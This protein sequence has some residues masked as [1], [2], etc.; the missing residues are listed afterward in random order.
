MGT[1]CPDVSDSCS[2]PTPSANG[3]VGGMFRLG[4]FCVWDHS[5]S[6]STGHIACL[7]CYKQVKHRRNQQAVRAWRGGVEGKEGPSASVS[8]SVNGAWSNT[9]QCCPLA[10]LPVKYYTKLIIIAF[11]MFLAIKGV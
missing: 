9:L 6:M 8:S 1:R 7:M 2:F 3:L 10:S 11:S 5:T 4:V